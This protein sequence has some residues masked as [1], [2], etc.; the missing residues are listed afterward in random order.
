EARV[1][2]DGGAREAPAPGARL[3][4][5]PVQERELRA[6]RRRPAADVAGGLHDDPRRGARGA[7]DSHPEL[8]RRPGPEPDSRAQRRLPHAERLPVHGAGAL[9]G[10]GGRRAPELRARHDGPGREPDRRHRAREDREVRVLHGGRRRQVLRRGALRRL[11]GRQAP[12][13]LVAPPLVGAG[14]QTIL[15]SAHLPGGPAETDGVVILHS[16]FGTTGTATAPF[17]LGR[18]TTHEI[19][20]WLNLRH[21]WGDD[22]TG[23][24]GSDFVADTPNQGGPNYGKPTFPQISCGNGPNGDMFVNFMDYVDD[25]AMVMFT[26]EQTVRMQAALDSNRSTL[27][28]TRPCA[29]LPLKD[30]VK[31]APKDLAKDLPKDGVK[32]SQKD[33]PKDPP[34]DL[35]K[36]LPKDPIKEHP[37]DLPKET[38]KDQ[39][40]DRPKD[41]P[42]DPTKEH[43][44]DSH[45]ED[46]KDQPKDLPKDLPKDPIKEHPKEILKDV[47][48]DL[49]KDGPKDLRKEPPKDLPKDSPKDLIK[50]P[51][52]DQPKELTKDVVKDL[53][54]DRPKELIKD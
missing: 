45:K 23:C 13:H 24:A 34:K 26:A 32:D 17:D 3:R 48:K 52:K 36:D 49:P 7:Q 11:A 38:A 35:P 51:P 18:T 8:L 16:A 44:K 27:G 2:H 29:K 9:R 4:G 6:A 28:V 41:L 42:K 50:D 47:V 40:K 46:V 30:Q 33:L 14:G 43:T 54:K 31:D 39:P 37:K 20:H 1:R 5:G 53:P 21:I 10:R 12:E 15:G 19:G 22:G 25:A